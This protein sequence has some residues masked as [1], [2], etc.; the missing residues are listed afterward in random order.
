MKHLPRP[1][2]HGEVFVDASALT[3]VDAWVPTVVR[4]LIEYRGRYRQTPV[5]LVPPHPGIARELY[6]DALGE[7]PSHVTWAR[8]DEDEV[9]EKQLGL[10]TGTL[11]RRR[12]P[13]R[14]VLPSQRIT[15]EAS[16]RQIGF[17]LPSYGEPARLEREIAFISLAFCELVDN[18]LRHCG[19]S[20]IGAIATILCDPNARTLELVV[21]DLGDGV[22]PADTKALTKSLDDPP[23]PE[24]RGINSLIASAQ[25]RGLDTTI[26]LV[27]NTEYRRH[28]DGHWHVTPITLHRPCFAAA[29]TVRW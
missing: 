16:A 29:V 25:R 19:A 5:T 20:P 2:A 1:E 7:L 24:V 14:V 8:V 9:P 10:L 27:S 13:G 12:H 21:V 15:D 3:S 11:F 17:L 18:A 22:P 4:A 6:I 28:Q 26:R 23:W